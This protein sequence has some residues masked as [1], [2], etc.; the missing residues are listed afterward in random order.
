MNMKETPERNRAMATINKAFLSCTSDN[1]QPAVNLVEFLCEC[2]LQKWI[3]N[4]ALNSVD[5]FSLHNSVKHLRSKLGRRNA[6][7]D[8][9]EETPRET[10]S[11]IIIQNINDPGRKATIPF[12]S[13]ALHAVLWLPPN[14]AT[15][16]SHGPLVLFKTTHTKN[17]SSPK[18]SKD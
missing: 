14:L 9:I 12:L 13:T 16:A 18:T 10:E 7:A 15:R 8:T 1:R 2:Q 6:P 11:Q 5:E 17:S 3:R 4:T